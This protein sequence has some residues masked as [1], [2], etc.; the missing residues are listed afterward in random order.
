M[1][2]DIYPL[3]LRSRAWEPV[4]GRGKC[5]RVVCYVLSQ[6]FNSF[7][8]ISGGQCASSDLSKTT[9]HLI[10]STIHHRYAK[11]F[12]N[13]R[14]SY[15]T[16]KMRFAH[17]YLISTAGAA[18]AQTV[19]T[20]DLFG[21][22][23]LMCPAGLYRGLHQPCQPEW[24]QDTTHHFN[25]THTCNVVDIV[26]PKG[27]FGGGIFRGTE[28]MTRWSP[29][30]SH[31]QSEVTSIKSVDKLCYSPSTVG[32]MYHSAVQMGRAAKS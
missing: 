30:D 14:H 32:T 6:F 19:W 26:K 23:T 13:L 16:F 18:A 21:S 9:S 2:V 7:F 15:D 24:P 29:R 1:F 12:V 28:F 11:S 5:S 8:C 10:P 4:F 20:D 31:H 3:F 22:T 17:I 27:P 25:T